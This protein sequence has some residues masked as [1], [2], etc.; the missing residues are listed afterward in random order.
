M[1]WP[2]FHALSSLAT[3]RHHKQSR[4]CLGYSPRIKS[5]TSVWSTHLI[6]NPPALIILSYWIANVILQP[7]HS[8]N[9]SIE[10]YQDLFW[11]PP[12]S[13]CHRSTHSRA[14]AENATYKQCY[15][16]NRA[17]KAVPRQLK[18][19]EAEEAIMKLPILV[20][21]ISLLGCALADMYLHYPRGSNNR[22]NEKSANRRNANRVFDSQ[23]WSSSILVFV[24]PIALYVVIYRLFQN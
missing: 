23:V 22:L 9:Q 7:T 17:I 6:C 2:L 18:W 13:P 15:L 8:F 1:F 16:G 5:P 11:F 10:V 3:T 21:S 4:R 12:Q 19:P 14:S 24:A 20:L